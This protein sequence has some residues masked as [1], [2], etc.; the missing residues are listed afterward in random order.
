MN[1][2]DP[3]Q[4][5]PEVHGIYYD[6]KTS[7]R[8]EVT[9]RV[10]AEM[11]ILTGDAERTCPVRLLRVSE[12][13]VHAGRKVT[14]PDGALLEIRDTAAF[15]RLLECTGHRDSM[16]SRWQQS[17]R[18]VALAAAGV[19]FMIAV[20]YLYLLPAAASLIAQET[21]PS[22]L[23][24]IGR[25]SLALLDRRILSPSALP[26]ARQE[27]IAARFYSLRPP[28][29]GAPSY[30]ILFRKSRIGPNALALPSGDIVLT[31]EL[32]A[33]SQHDDALMGVLAHELG[34]L[35]ER[36]LMR[37][38]I[39]TT[40]IAAGSFALFGDLSAIVAQL[41]AVLLELRYSRDAEREADRYALRM[42]ADNGIDSRAMAELFERI[43][44]ASGGETPPYLST[45][46]EPR[47]RAKA[48]RTREH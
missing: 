33:L 12:R 36:H 38:L 30:Q 26:P 1:Q 20:G 34:H 6:G 40:A 9:L 11:A 35:H 2:P 23:Q 16:V 47:E 41:P 19:L 3:V 45:H 43:A 18:A 37:R 44:Q 24:S 46:P 14:F 22:A 27:Q 39:Q 10:E 29:D 28:S 5:P 8:H 48:M 31:D 17:W 13:T 15:S 42:L 25:E 4:E 32:I 21:P 7:R